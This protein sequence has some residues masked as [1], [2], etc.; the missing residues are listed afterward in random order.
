[1][2]LP[3]RRATVLLS[4]GLGGSPAFWKPQLRRWSMPAGA[5]SPTTSAAP[6]AAPT[7]CPRRLHDRR[8]G[9]RRARGPRRHRHRAVP[10]RIGHALG[11]LVGLQLALDDTARVA[12]PGA[13]QRLVQAQPAFG[14][15]LRGAAGAARRGR[16]AR[17][18]RGAADL[19]VPGRL[20]RRARRR[21]AAEVDHAFAHFPGEANMRA[22]IGALRAFDV[23][24]RLADMPCPRWSRR[25]GR[26]ARALDLLAALADGLPRD[27]RLRAARRPRPQRDRS[28]R[29]QPHPA[30][31]PRR[32][33]LTDQFHDPSPGHRR[34][35]A[36]FTTPAATTAGPASRCPT[37][38]CARSTTSP[39]WGR[40]RP[41]ARPARF[42]FV[43]TPEGKER[44]APAALQGQPRQDD[45]GARHGDRGL[46]PGLLRQA[47]QL[48]PHA[49]ARSW[50]TGS[51]G[52][53]ARNGLPQRQPAGGY[54]ILA[55]RSLGLDAGPM[56][57]FDKAKVDA[58][59]F[60]GTTGPPT[61]SSTSATATRRRCSA[62]CRAWTSTKPASWPEASGALN[63]IPS[64]RRHR[65]PALPKATATRCRGWARR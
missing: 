15:L 31:L 30:R 62:A 1:M 41:T 18:C 23:A 37:T 56:S 34:A 25:D 64:R 63:V 50:F 46:G 27:T 51:P 49:D 29:L 22:R 32:R 9:A 35:R 5:W 40:P 6:A 16:P 20:V 11:G 12:E 24:A 58:A 60:E 48:F 54:L 65:L 17:L 19:P 13:G 55:A 52:A 21:V 28:G 14:A 38:C 39:A 4:S 7:R 10:L 33:A 43:R 61:S 8:H 53:G 57:G 47:A 2:G 3:L 59:F 45:D 36:L 44:L 26:R 42:V